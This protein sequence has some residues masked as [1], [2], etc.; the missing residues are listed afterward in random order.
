MLTYDVAMNEIQRFIAF[1]STI[2]GILLNNGTRV[3]FFKQ[4][5]IASCT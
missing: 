1:M 5:F 2:F 3:S 4:N